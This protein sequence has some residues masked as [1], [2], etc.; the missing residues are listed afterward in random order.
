MNAPC[1][2]NACDG[3]VSKSLLQLGI[4]SPRGKRCWSSACLRGVRSNP[5]YTGHIYGN[6][7]TIAPGSTTRGHA[8]HGPT[9]GGPSPRTA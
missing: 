3:G 5:T 1:L 4:K 7:T 6:P 2:P 9:R 8:P